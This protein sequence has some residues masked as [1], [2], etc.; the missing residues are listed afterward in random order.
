MGHAPRAIERILSYFSKVKSMGGHKYMA[1]CPKHVDKTP[2][3]AIKERSGGTI[4][5]HCFSCGANGVE[6]CQALGI[7]PTELFPDS[8]PA[9]KKHYPRSAINN[10]SINALR[11]DFVRLLIIANGMKNAGDLSEDDRKFIADLAIKVNDVANE[12][13]SGK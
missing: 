2:S 3:L 5:M 10:R 8:N 4:L 13:F 11:D 9:A 7:E 12:L 1:S 6:I